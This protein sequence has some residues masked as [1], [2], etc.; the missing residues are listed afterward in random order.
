VSVWIISAAQSF[1]L[2]TGEIRDKQYVAKVAFSSNGETWPSFAHSFV[3]FNLSS[4]LFK[5][6]IEFTEFLLAHNMLHQ[7]LSFHVNKKCCCKHY[8]GHIANLT[9]DF[10]TASHPCCGTAKS[11]NSL[12][13]SMCC[14]CCRIFET[15]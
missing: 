15:S 11:H 4:T 9:S 12:K 10:F 6:Q 5:R 3:R 13:F 8:G 2:A 7:T 14:C 1:Q